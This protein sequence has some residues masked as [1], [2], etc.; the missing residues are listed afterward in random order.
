MQ[1]AGAGLIAQ[2]LPESKQVALVGTGHVHYRWISS[3]KAFIIGQ[4]LGNASLLQNYFGEPDAVWVAGVAPG[5]VP[6]MMIV[7]MHQNGSE[8]GF[9]RLVKV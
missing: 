6:F 9:F 8:I 1:I 7:P 2:S 5:Q 3:H 4:T